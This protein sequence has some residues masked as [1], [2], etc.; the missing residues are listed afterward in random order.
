MSID[1]REFYSS[2]IRTTKIRTTPCRAE[3]QK[4]GSTQPAAEGDALVLELPSTVHN[5]DFGYVVAY[6][7][8]RVVVEACAKSENISLV[9]GTLTIRD[10]SKLLELRLFGETQELY[11]LRDESVTEGDAWIG[12]LIEDLGDPKNVTTDQTSAGSKEMGDSTERETEEDC[13]F[14]DELHQVLPRVARTL[15]ESEQP[16]EISGFGQLQET[17]WIRVRNYFNATGE[18]ERL[19]WRFVGFEAESALK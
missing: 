10:A 17:R 13:E 9:D 14:Y 12:R 18:L 6:F 7:T 3:I 8:D 16:A 15:S 1:V 4:P 5:A 2:K 11:L 19:D